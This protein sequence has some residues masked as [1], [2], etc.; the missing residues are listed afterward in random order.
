MRIAII[1]E[2]FLPKLDG[3]TRTLAMLLEYLQANDHQALLLGVGKEPAFTCP[4]LPGPGSPPLPPGDRRRWTSLCRNATIT[5]GCSS[6][7]HWLSE[8]R[9]AGGC[10]CF[11]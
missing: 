3:V 9:C 1:T 8:R 4:G 11:G 2:N 5:G 7:F 6:H 10:L